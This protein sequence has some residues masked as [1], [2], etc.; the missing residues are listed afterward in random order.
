MKPIPHRHHA[1]GERIGF[2][3][4]G[5]WSFPVGT[6]F[7]KHFELDTDET[8]PGP[9]RRLETRL[10]VLTEDGTAYGMTYK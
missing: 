4:T 6:V 8:G 10:L 1:A 2:V 7:V 5:E 9:R 3:R